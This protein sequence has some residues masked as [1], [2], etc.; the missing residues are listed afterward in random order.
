MNAR[1][2]FRC[3]R[4][5]AV[6]VAVSTS[7]AAWGDDCTAPVTQRAMQKCAYDEFLAAQAD[8]ADLHRALSR[9]LAPDARAKLLR[10][11]QAWMRYRGA[12]CEYESSAVAGGSAQRMV[13]Y[14]CLTRMTRSRVDE[15]EAMANCREGGIACVRR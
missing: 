6:L 11:Q 1:C 15:L 2:L 13:Q 12:A 8:Y 7:A 4:S 3:L 14:Q 10:M 5:I 9:S